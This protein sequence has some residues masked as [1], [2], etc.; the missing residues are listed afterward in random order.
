MG[1]D[2]DILYLTSAGLVVWL[3][4]PL[5]VSL[6][7]PTLCS[8][9]LNINLTFCQFAALVWPLCVCIVC[10]SE[11]W[12]SRRFSG[13]AVN[14][15]TLLLEE[16]PGL[17]YVGARGALYALQASDISSS[18]HT[19]STPLACLRFVFQIWDHCLEKMQ[20]CRFSAVRIE[21]LVIRTA[22]IFTL[23]GTLY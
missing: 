19:V 20:P 11:L 2:V 15:S 14:Y 10:A 7:V 5:T 13:S 18:S 8:K 6:Q 21:N 22:C 16:E 12:K 4:A 9:S 23:L 1:V 17:L 3:F